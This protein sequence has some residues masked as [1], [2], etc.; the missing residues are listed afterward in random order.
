MRRPPGSAARITAAA[1]W[2]AGFTPAVD[3]TAVDTSAGISCVALVLGATDTW[4]PDTKSSW[5]FPNDGEA[6]YNHNGK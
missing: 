5:S 1:K 4:H 6:S 3:W 2:T